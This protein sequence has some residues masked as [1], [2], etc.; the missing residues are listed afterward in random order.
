MFQTLHSPV[1]LFTV[2]SVPLSLVIHEFAHAIVAD[3]LGD[4]TPRLYGRV[5]LNPMS[6]LD[7][8][9]LLMMLFGP[10]GWAKPTP[11]NPKNFKRP[12]LAYALTVLAGPLSNLLLACIGFFLLK[13]LWNP[14]GLNAGF[15][16]R[17]LSVF[18]V[19][20]VNLFI[21]NL[22]PVPPLDGSRLLG[23]LFRG[24]RANTY[25]NFETYGPFVL[26]LIVIIPPLQGMILTPLFSGTL[27]FV[28]SWFGFQYSPLY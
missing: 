4:P 6:H 25:R 13:V 23:L 9:G 20:N 1:F 5:T 8:L 15:I 22:I 2:I 17:L 27:S 24:H 28:A 26:L 11:V 14:T 10:I 18:A 19:V 3:L 12:R 16:S 7:V 21:F